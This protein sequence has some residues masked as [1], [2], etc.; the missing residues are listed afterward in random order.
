MTQTDTATHKFTDMNAVELRAS[1]AQFEGLCVVATVNPDGTPDAAIFVPTMPDDEHVIF[2]LADNHT[3][4]NLERT[5]K[6]RLVYD[7]TNPRAA[8]KAARHAGARLDVSLV[9]QDGETAEE[10]EHVAR[11]FPRMN[12]AVVILRIERILPIG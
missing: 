4:A 8:E 2:M 9:R 10:Y 11:N 6:A 1:M 3:R 7:V 5:G 12:P